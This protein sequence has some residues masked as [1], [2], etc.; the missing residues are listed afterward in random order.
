MSPRHPATSPT[1]PAAEFS[2]LGCF[3]AVPGLGLPGR[4]SD[5]QNVK[6]QELWT[7][8]NCCELLH[9]INTRINRNRNRNVLTAENYLSS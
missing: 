4:V 1:H 6:N 2:D 5:R 9:I 7:V 3:Q 8:A